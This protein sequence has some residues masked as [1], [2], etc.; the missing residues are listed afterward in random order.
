MIEL[1][2]VTIEGFRSFRDESQVDFLPKGLALISGRDV[3]TGGSNGSGKSSVLEAVGYALG[4]SSIPATELKNRDSDKL[5][6]TLEVRVSGALWAITRTQKSLNIYVDGK[7]IEGMRSLLD[8]KLQTV[9]QSPEIFEALTYRRQGDGGFFL[10]VQDSKMKAFLSQCFPELEKADN[11]VEVSA[12]KQKEIKAL[13]DAA[14]IKLDGKKSSL[15]MAQRLVA[16]PDAIAALKAELKGFETET[17]FLLESEPPELAARQAAVDTAEAAL[18]DALSRLTNAQVA[19][20]S[21]I[22]SAEAAAGLQAIIDDKKAAETQRA[23]IE[24]ATGSLDAMIATHTAAQREVE[25]EIRTA[26]SSESKIPGIKAEAERVF[27]E[28]SEMKKSVCPTCKREWADAGKSLE[29][30]SAKLKL[31]MSELQAA[32]RAAADIAPAETR[33]ENILLELSALNKQKSELMATWSG[34]SERLRG[35]DRRRKE[36]ED[37]DQASARK[38]VEVAQ[39]EVAAAQSANRNA[40][41]ELQATKEA[42]ARAVSQVESQIRLVSAKIAEADRGHKEVSRLQAEIADLENDQ[43][44][45][46]KTLDVEVAIQSVVKEVI[47]FF[48]DEMLGEVEASANAYLGR[49]PNV[50][51]FTITISSSDEMKNGNVKSKIN[52]A[53]SRL[54]KEVPVRS[55]SGGQKAAISMMLDLALIGAVRRRTNVRSNWLALDE[56]MDGMDVQSK[57]A[58]LEILREY[59]QDMLVL[60]IDHSTELKE[61]FDASIMVEYDGS[62]SRVVA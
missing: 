16:S 53:L 5:S 4:L 10:G 26:R 61:S 62:T 3:R 60:V 55:L 35:F 23:E 8:E 28:I 45:K 51:E 49:I 46:S 20:S 50:N 1:V 47:S 34:L 15:E 56:F 14:K 6:V 32:K 54:G 12:Q 44:E 2:S 36:I 33:R 24:A 40:A 48:F 39:A 59:S 22:L 30:R 19:L 18:A 42:R 41:A 29:E 31:L 25:K 52:V 21:F 13:L 7:K 37:A 57:E 9:I 27:A 58:A 17:A 43:L 11:A 38:N